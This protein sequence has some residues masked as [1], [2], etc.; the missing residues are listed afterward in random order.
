MVPRHR[1]GG[2][3]PWALRSEPMRPSKSRCTV[4]RCW[5]LVRKLP[6]SS[7]AAPGP[8]CSSSSGWAPAAL[9]VPAAGGLSAAPRRPRRITRRARTDAHRTIRENISAT[10]SCRRSPALRPRLLTRNAPC[11][12]RSMP[13]AF[14]PRRSP[15][16]TQATPNIPACGRPPGMP[17]A[18]AGAP[19]S[20]RRLPTPWPL[21]RL[22]SRRGRFERPFVLRRRRVERWSP[23]LQTL[24]LAPLQS[25]RR[26][27]S[28]FRR[29]PRRSSTRG[30][31]SLGA[32]RA[33]KSAAT[34]GAPRH[35]RLPA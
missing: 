21:G 23:R 3:G 15:S 16:S 6:R 31:A 12:S 10:T 18:T 29:R 8:S 33:P 32:V 1:R 27:A 22:A 9:A 28:R 35:R 5:H 14:P 2:K 13:G 4:A 34:R 30:R 17:A 7:A 25:R 24:P 26:P 19:T 20:L 11:R